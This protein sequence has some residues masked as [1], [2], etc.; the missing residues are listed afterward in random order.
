MPEI[1][2]PEITLIDNGEA[3]DINNSSFLDLYSDRIAPEHSASQ[4]TQSFQPINI[5]GCLKPINNHI[6]FEAMNKKK[7]VDWWLCI[8]AGQAEDASV[9]DTKGYRADIWALFDQV[10]HCVTGKPMIICKRCGAI[11]HHPNAISCSSK[12]THGITALRRHF[13]RQICQARG[14]AQGK[15]SNLQRLLRHQIRI[16]FFSRKT[17]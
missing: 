6:L 9:W 2:L 3:C 4:K 15:G 7:F 1:Q 8:S 16:F 14:Q 13:T 11:L 10:A 17:I 12:S 5:P